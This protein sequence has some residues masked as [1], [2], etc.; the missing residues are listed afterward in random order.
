MT[1]S[2][3][4]GAAAIALGLSGCFIPFKDVREGTEIASK[5]LTWVK[6]GE[7]DRAAILARLGEPD[8]DFTDRHTI[9]YAWAGIAGMLCGS[10]CV[11]I[12]M[13]RALVVR[14]DAAGK[15]A[16]FSFL[17]RPPSVPRYDALERWRTGEPTGWTAV[18]GK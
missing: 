5:D 1:L 2:R 8:L 7:T 18:L 3:V 15:V 11:E 6:V 14:F 17:D 13:S 4:A 16:A 9:A 10:G 12:P